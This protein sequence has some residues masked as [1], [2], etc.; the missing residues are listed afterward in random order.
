MVR[1]HHCLLQIANM[2][3]SGDVGDDDLELFDLDPDDGFDF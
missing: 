2:M 1:A 3:I